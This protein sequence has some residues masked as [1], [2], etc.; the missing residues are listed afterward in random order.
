M[1]TDTAL[2]WFRNDLR[3]HDHEAVTHALQHASTVIAVYVLDPR[4][5]ALSSYGFPRMGAFR[6]KF[7]VECLADLQQ[8]LQKMGTQ[9][10]IL[11][12]HTEQ[13]LPEF[14]Q[15]QGANSVYAHR[16]V[17]S[18]E[19]R[20]EARL[21]AELRHR[22]IETA[23][24]WGSTLIHLN[25]LATPVNNLPEIFT[26][27][28]KQNERYAPIRTPLPYPTEWKSAKP[29]QQTVADL[30]FILPTMTEMGHF[31]EIIP[32]T[33]AVMPFV[34]G[35]SAALSRLS[36]YFWEDDSLQSYKETRNG[37]IGASYSSKFSAW[38]AFGCLSPRYVYAEVQRYERER[39]ANDS[40]YWLIFELLWRDYFRFMVKKHGNHVFLPTGMKNAAAPS[41]RV[42][43]QLF[44]AWTQGRTGEPFVDANMRELAAT[45]FMSNRGR[46][47]VASYFVHNLHL[48]WRMGAAWFESLLIDY[49]VCSNY[50][51]WNYVAG[52]GND[53]REGRQF[54]PAKQA[55][56]YDPH[57]A[58][59][60]LWG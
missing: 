41:L 53:P 13:V 46:Q 2:V 34:G 17:A 43:W 56:Q 37:L 9:L 12:G 14:A 49:D 54:N 3:L 35:E 15:A 10:V 51:N 33:R 29:W 16:E 42:D 48:D 55:K 23:W 58:Y 4:S 20:I 6:A 18:E 40:T 25:D 11:R 24:F 32:D 47:N 27:F 60:Q 57:G 36:R 38:L 52:V 26:N 59:Q 1:K 7:L 31:S 44:E 30:D 45:G 50:G 39:V 28:R 19:V 22:H 21:E 8:R 5:Y